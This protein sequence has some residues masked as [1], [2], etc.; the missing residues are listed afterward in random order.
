LG[1]NESGS[2]EEEDRFEPVLTHIDSF[3]HSHHNFSFASLNNSVFKKIL[4]NK[5]Y[6]E[7]QPLPPTLPQ[8]TPMYTTQNFLQT[9]FLISGKHIT[10]R[11]STTPPPFTRLYGSASM[12]L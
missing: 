4:R 3:P 11:L 10:L 5:K 2:K 6:Q 7:E 12:K 1:V 8:V 9:W